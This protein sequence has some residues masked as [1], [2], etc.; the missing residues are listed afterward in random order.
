LTACT[1]KYTHNYIHCIIDPAHFVNTVMGLRIPDKQMLYLSV[2]YPL[3]EDSR[4]QKLVSP[5]ELNR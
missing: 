2:N 4:V 3:F 5:K 1:R